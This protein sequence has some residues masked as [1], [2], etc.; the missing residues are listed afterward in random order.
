MSERD[1]FIA[2]LD[3][4]DPV[5][6]DAYLA[7]ACGSDADLRRRVERLLRLHKDAGSFLEQ[8]AVAPGETVDPH[9][10]EPP[11]GPEH[12]KAQGIRGAEP[13]PPAE[14]AGTRLGPYMLLQKLGEGGMGAVWAL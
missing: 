11:T 12:A 14:A 3:R 7:Q 10:A 5:E 13:T 9:P 6:R 4:D 2:A 1:L 8:Q